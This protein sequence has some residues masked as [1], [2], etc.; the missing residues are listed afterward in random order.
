LDED[1]VQVV[2]HHY[3]LEGWVVE[4]LLEY[5]LVVVHAADDALDEG[6]GEDEAEVLDGIG[7]R[8]LGLLVVAAQKVGD[9]PD[10]AGVVVD[11]GAALGQEET[12]S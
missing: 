8:V 6:V 12:P 4:D 9:G 5:V 11:R 1:T 7:T 2:V 3:A 10:E